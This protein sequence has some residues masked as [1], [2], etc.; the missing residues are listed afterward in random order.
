MNGGPP[1]LATSSSNAPLFSV[2][3]LNWNGRHLLEECLESI[4]SQ[5]FRD[6]ETIVVDNGSTDGSV[7]WVKDRYGDAVS[8]VALPSN[9][10]FAGGNNAGIRV[11]R[12][13]YVILLNNDTA[14]DPGWLAALSDAVRRHP[15]AGMFTPKILNYY[16]RDE[17][18]NTGHLIYPD[19]MARGRHR[20]EKD[21]GRFDEEGEVLSPSGCAGCYDRRM[22]DEIGLLDDAFFAYG[23][24]AD[25][26]LRARWAGWTC[27]YV[28][29]AVV[30]HKYSATSGTYS[31]QKAFLA[32]RNRL[33]LLFKNFPV[34]DIL[35]SP[36]Y[37]VLRYSLHLKGAITGKGASGRFAREFSVGALLRVILN[38]E[39]AAL[40]GLPEILRKRRECRTHRRIG[41]R[42]FRG[43]VR[44]FA[45][46]AGEVA[47]KD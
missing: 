28:P 2:I 18:D 9:L 29:S 3:I 46:T 14:V 38:A 45:L 16:R 39:V 15:D 36:F 21:D 41:T 11:A 40:R 22:L 4:S 6:F 26:G 10:G 25:L 5:S 47:L 7:D 44:R 20:L 37:T 1:D 24:D 42:E 30:Y 33:W 19:G 27:T 8:T 17:I 32:E 43:L 31:P 34:V 13:R 35:R 12:G 23:E